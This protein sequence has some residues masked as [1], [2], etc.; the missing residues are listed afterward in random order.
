M[1]SD[2]TWRPSHERTPAIEA[3]TGIAVLPK[4]LLLV[5]RAHAERTAN[6]VHWSVFPSGGHF[7]P[8]EEPARLVEDIR[9]C[10]RSL[11]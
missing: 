2:W 10:F 9:A 5:P 3:P 7:A 8:A 4:Q 11:R 1:G 6:L